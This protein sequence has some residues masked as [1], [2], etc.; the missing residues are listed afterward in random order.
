MRLVEIWDYF[1]RRKRL[2]FVVLGVIVI[3]SVGWTK[4]GPGKNEEVTPE[5]PKTGGTTEINGISCDFRSTERVDSNR[6][7]GMNSSVDEI[8]ASELT[9]WGAEAP[10]AIIKSEDYNANDGEKIESVIITLGILAAVATLGARKIIF[11]R[12]VR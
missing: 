9:F 2:L 12:Y 8:E 6:G 11:D 3:L 1:M 10:V 7:G 5:V 4:L